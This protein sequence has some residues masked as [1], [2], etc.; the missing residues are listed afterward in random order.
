M[1]E[2]QKAEKV[3]DECWFIFSITGD[4]QDARLLIEAVLNLDLLLSAQ[5]EVEL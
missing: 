5:D 2:I 1:S 4:P 3:L